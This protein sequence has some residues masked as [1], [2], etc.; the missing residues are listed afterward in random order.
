MAAISGLFRRAG[1][2]RVDVFR[3][4]RH[5]L[6][7]E[8]RESEKGAGLPRSLASFSA[9]SLM[10]ESWLNLWS[11]MLELVS[12]MLTNER[13]PYFYGT[14][15]S[16]KWNN[17]YGLNSFECCTVYVFKEDSISSLLGR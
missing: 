13:V 15:S 1:F 12:K 2:E 16:L 7:R 8:R 3:P 11:V 4:F 6:W 17:L 5:L 10:H 9:W 14:F